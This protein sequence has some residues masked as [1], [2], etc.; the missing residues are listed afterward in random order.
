MREISAKQ[1]FWICDKRYKHKT[2]RN[3]YDEL[4]MLHEYTYM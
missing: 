4:T 1:Y 3:R 2:K